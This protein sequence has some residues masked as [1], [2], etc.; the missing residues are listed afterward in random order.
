MKPIEEA[1]KTVYVKP[2]NDS[3]F[4]QQKEL[5]ETFFT[6]HAISETEYRDNLADLT[7]RMGKS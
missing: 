1:L 4:F 5:L 2:T 7:L 3:L 6:H